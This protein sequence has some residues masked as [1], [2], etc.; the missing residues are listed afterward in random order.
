[1][2]ATPFLKKVCKFGALAHLA[3]KSG[4][5]LT[6]TPYFYALVNRYV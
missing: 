6:K 4:V 5:L 1:M 3:N 2:S